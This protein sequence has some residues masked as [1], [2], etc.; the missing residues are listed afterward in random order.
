M[1]RPPW[2]LTVLDDPRH[3]HAVVFGAGDYRQRTEDRPPPPV[4]HQGDRLA[5]GPLSARIEAL[6]GHPRFVTLS[7]DGT[8]DV[9]WAHLASHVVFTLDWRSL[10]LMCSCGIRFATLTHAASCPVLRRA[11]HCDGRA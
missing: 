6:L 3:F 4:L 10:A 8:P 9:I 7:F 2:T 5:L 11:S 1:T